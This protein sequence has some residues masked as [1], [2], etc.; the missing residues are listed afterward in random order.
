VALLPGAF[1]DPRA[2]AHST[3]GDMVMRLRVRECD[4]TNALYPSK[5]APGIEGM[6]TNDLSYRHY[7]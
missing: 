5:M 7:N 3:T 1:I 6:A 4:S 2:R